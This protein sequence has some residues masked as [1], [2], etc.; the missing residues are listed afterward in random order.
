M[1][2]LLNSLPSTQTTLK[3]VDKGVTY[4]C[5]Y[6]MWKRLA[7]TVGTIVF[8]FVMSGFLSGAEDRIDLTGEIEDVQDSGTLEPQVISDVKASRRVFRGFVADN[9]QNVHCK[10][11]MK[12]RSDGTTYTM[13]V[14][15]C[16]GLDVKYNDE[17][18]AQQVHRCGP[19]SGPC[20]SSRSTKYV[21]EQDGRRF[22]SSHTPHVRCTI[23]NSVNS[24]SY[25]FACPKKGDPI[26]LVRLKN[27]KL[28]IPEG[29]W[30]TVTLKIKYMDPNGI[31]R[32]QTITTQ[33]N[34]PGSSKYA[35]GGTIP[36]YYSP[37]HKKIYLDDWNGSTWSGYFLTLVWLAA[38]FKTFDML[39]FFNYSICRIRLG[40]QAFEKVENKFGFDV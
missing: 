8:A 27:N 33:M 18:G 38:V 24:K 17:G 3:T 25:S 12:N 36:V 40:S 37:K 5:Y 13:K 21:V 6:A 23:N 4:V 14:C 1:Q 26:E 20:A 31:V 35:V 9:S 16:D 10:D 7:S 32:L 30:N 28:M 29:N 39:S 19:V 34:G 15:V 2:S 22:C 11:V